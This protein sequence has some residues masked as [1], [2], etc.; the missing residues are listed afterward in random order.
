MRD[1]VLGGR[2]S[3]TRRERGTAAVEFALIVPV[4]VLLVFGIVSYGMML[5][6]RQTLSQAATEGARA[7]AVQL[8]PSQRTSSAE[9]AIDDALATLSVGGTTL[10]CDNPHVTCQIGAAVSCGT[11]TAQCVTVTVTYPYRDH[12]VIPSVPLVDRTLPE[13]LSYS[14]T[15]RVS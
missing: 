3:S 4:L 2:T 13:S 9:E 11:G 8:D 10:S 6:F 5:S 1:C 7:A 14:A 15:V 12:P